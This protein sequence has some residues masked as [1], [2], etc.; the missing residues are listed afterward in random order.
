MRLILLGSPGAG[1]GTQAE[2]ITKH[3]GIPQISTGDMLRSAIRSGAEIGL[4]AKA[5]MDAG[6]LVP[7]E[8]MINLVK[9]RIAQPDCANGFLFDGFPRTIP[10]AEAIRKEGIILDHVIE[11]HVDD[12]Q[13]IKRLTGRRIHPGS[14]RIYHESFNPPKIAGK[15]DVTGEALIQRDDDSEITV[16]NRLQVYQE[17]TK[18]LIEYYLKLMD[19]HNA[20][21]PIFTRIDGSQSVDNV[22][23]QIF[24]VLDKSSPENNIVNITSNNFDATI[25]NNDLVLIDFWAAWCSPCQSFGKVYKDMAKEYPT[26][27]FGKVN[28]DEETELAAD[29]QIR[30]IPALL[31]F[32]KGIAVFSESG[33]LPAE[34]IRDLIKQAQALDM[35][36]LEK[37]LKE[38][39]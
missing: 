5:I 8:I 23:A 3:F 20:Q 29:F 34:A 24:N 26:L 19:T 12:E 6:G 33:V 9:E 39:A 36:T 16:R 2:Y 28:V 17:Q 13:I 35:A 32:R 10:Q 27:V 18:P 7:D 37:A 30:S 38:K 1:K 21:A 22:R 14:G 4:A 25:Q 31:I 15:D 11:I